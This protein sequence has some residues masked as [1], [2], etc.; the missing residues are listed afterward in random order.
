[1]NTIQLS[2]A[3][4]AVLGLGACVSGVPDATRSLPVT[5]TT[6]ELAATG[7][8]G[9]SAVT[10]VPHYA[11][12]AVRVLVPESLRVSEANVYYP[13]AD[14]VWRGDPRA[15]RHTQVKAIFE[16]A[17]ARGTAGMTEGRPVFV[18]LEVTRFH[19][20]T[21]KT[22]YTIGG[23][24]S[25]KFMLTVRDAATGA[26]LDGPR[27]VVADIKASGGS[28]AVEEDALGRT[29]KVVIEEHLAAVAQRELTRPLVMAPGAGVQS[30][31]SRMD[32]D[33]TRIAN[34]LTR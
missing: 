11:I 27:L 15:D 3:L 25:L 9:A 13:I 2:F 20:L 17:F 33:P 24:H 32:Y 16:E 10:M 5:A 14:I 1:M 18:D 28:V 29:Q 21:E 23:V 12:Q 19:C 31:V 6:G 8:V 26:V 7:T 4:A 22:R 34:A 30:Y